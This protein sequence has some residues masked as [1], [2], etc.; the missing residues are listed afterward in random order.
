MFNPYVEAELTPNLSSSAPTTSSGINASAVNEVGKLPIHGAYLL[1]C[2]PTLP[3]GEGQDVTP[4]T[5]T[6]SG[7]ETSM[8]RWLWEV[9]D[10]QLDE[11]VA[12]ERK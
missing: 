11:A 3:N 9:S 7:T 5:N 8:R 12:A 6:T 10:A 4:I 1:D 2:A